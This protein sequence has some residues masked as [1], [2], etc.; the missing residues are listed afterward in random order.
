M[1]ILVDQNISFRLIPLVRSEFPNIAH[2]KDLGLMDYT[3]HKIF[4]YARQNDFLAVFT[5]D[6][7]FN[8]LQ[9]EFG[10]P[11][12]IVWLRVGNCSTKVLADIL[13]D[14]SVIIKEFFS[15]PETDCLEILKLDL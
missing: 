9:L 1:K 4:H 7:D 10:I 11:P 12:K 6:E 3:D 13:L 5:L 2:V 14:K 8:N 15:D